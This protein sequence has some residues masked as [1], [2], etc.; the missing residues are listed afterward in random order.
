MFSYDLFCN[1]GRKFKSF[2]VLNSL[3]RISLYAETEV[4]VKVPKRETGFLK[5]QHIL[6]HEISC[7]IIL[8]PNII[9]YIGG[10]VFLYPERVVILKYK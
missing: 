3:K 8:H 6:S 10:H 1:S 4:A 7:N 2:S 5:G 9:N